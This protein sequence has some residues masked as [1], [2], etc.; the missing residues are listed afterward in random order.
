MQQVSMQRH[1][2][3]S[4]TLVCRQLPGVEGTLL[5][6]QR[7]PGPTDPGSKLALCSAIT[8]QHGATHITNIHTHPPA[9]QR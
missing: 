3:R 1:V 4:I 2:C 5:R 8:Y 6:Q 7:P 9:S